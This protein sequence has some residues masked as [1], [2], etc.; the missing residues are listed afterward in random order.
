SKL[1]RSSMKRRRSWMPTAPPAAP[2]RKRRRRRST[3][4]PP[5]DP[6]P[7][8]RGSAAAEPLKRRR[9]RRRGSGGRLLARGMEE[10]RLADRRLHRF[11]LEGLGDQEGGFGPFPGQQPL[12]E[13]GDEDDRNIELAQDVLD[14]VN[15][16]RAVRQLDIRQ[17]QSR[18][19]TRNGVHGLV[20][21]GGGAGD[22]VAQLLHQAFDVGR[23]DGLVL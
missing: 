11:R 3:L 13:G 12:R 20:V 23:D 16:R 4:L 15:A 18:R 5:P 21:G 19:V 8:K 9:G 22:P 6:P 2:A 14:R 10:Q 1:C 7:A 17:N